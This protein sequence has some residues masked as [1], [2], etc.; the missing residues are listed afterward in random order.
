MI[1]FTQFL[2]PDGRR[3]L[4]TFDAGA[5]VNSLA[6]ELIGAGYRFEC[7]VLRTGH[8]HMDCCGPTREGDGPIALQVSSNGPEVVAAV[9]QLVRDAHAAWR[10]M[11]H[12]G[13]VG[14][15]AETVH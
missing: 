9:E 4:R 14:P 6:N 10:T 15:A 8:V 11:L 3:E 12:G 13:A 5:E 1:L 7:E 2:L